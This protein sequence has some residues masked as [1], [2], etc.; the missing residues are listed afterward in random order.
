M[1]KQITF[2]ETC[3]TN[4]RYALIYWLHHNHHPR[5]THTDTGHVVLDAPGYARNYTARIPIALWRELTERGWIK[6]RN[7]PFDSRT[8]MPSRNAIRAAREKGWEF[9]RWPRS[10]S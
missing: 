2:N 8:Y 6:L 10:E 5:V 7:H 4:S 1:G 3:S 9:T